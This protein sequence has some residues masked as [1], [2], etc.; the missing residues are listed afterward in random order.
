MSCKVVQVSHKDATHRCARARS[1]S[2]VLHHLAALTAAAATASAAGDKHEDRTN[3]GED[4]GDE[5]NVDGGAVLGGAGALLDLGDEQVEG[6]KV[7]DDGDGVDYEGDARGE[8]GHDATDGAAREQAEEE[9]DEQDTRADGVQD[10]DA[11]KGLRSVLAGGAEVGVVDALEYVGR[12]VADAGAG[13][14]GAEES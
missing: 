13:A 1:D 6:D 11:G 8:G 3:E 14:L 10:E 7:D 4:G 9:G 5:S 12:V 2:L